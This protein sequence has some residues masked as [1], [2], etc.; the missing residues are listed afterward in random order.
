MEAVTVVE[1]LEVAVEVE[2]EV[3]D[4]VVPTAFFASGVEIL[5]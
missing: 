4:C 3:C 1:V 5:V 2:V